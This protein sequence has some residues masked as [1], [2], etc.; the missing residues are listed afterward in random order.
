MLQSQIV[1]CSQSTVRRTQKMNL[2]F[3]PQ[4]LPSHRPP[5]A[6]KLWAAV[7]S[8]KIPLL[9][10]WCVAHQESVLEMLISLLGDH[11]VAHCH[12][13]ICDRTTFQLD[14]IHLSWKRFYQAALFCGI[15]RSQ[16]LSFRNGTFLRGWV[17]G[18]VW[19]EAVIFLGDGVP[20]GWNQ[21]AESNLT[22]TRLQSANSVP[23]TCVRGPAGSNFSTTSAS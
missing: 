19:E 4:S 8:G 23:G 2:G 7:R 3:R 6:A 15:Y 11:S 9:V 14:P 12:A 22:G 21:E 10:H 1:L 20:V 17:V 16:L 13:C 18:S 5:G